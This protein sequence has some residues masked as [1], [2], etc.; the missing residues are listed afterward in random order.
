MLLTIVTRS[1]TGYMNDKCTVEC[2]EQFA[3]ELAQNMYRSN[4][5]NK[6]VEVYEGRNLYF[7]D[8][9]VKP[10]RIVSIDQEGYWTV[11]RKYEIL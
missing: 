1:N 6:Y 4:K 11:D 5:D 10:W 2:N 8:S 9:R 7:G 3:I